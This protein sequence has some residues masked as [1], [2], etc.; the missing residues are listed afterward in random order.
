[1]STNC[2][3]CCCGQ[4]GSVGARDVLPTPLGFWGHQL[5]PP[6]VSFGD[7][8][9][10]MIAL[11]SPQALN[12]T[13]GTK[14]GNFRV[15]PVPGGP[16]QAGALLRGA[17][18][19][20]A[21]WEASELILLRSREGHQELSGHKIGC[22]QGEMT[23]SSLVR[24]LRGEQRGCAAAARSARGHPTPQPLHGPGDLAAP[25]DI[26]NPILSSSLGL[27]TGFFFFFF[28]LL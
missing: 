17:G 25:P 6:S 2:S 21:G 10:K 20:S 15:L 16:G 7:K 12:Q 1:M 18:L 8:T 4:Q 27:T 22:K 19:G 13:R 24:W 3:W 5:C 26:I 11:G 9:G 28:N 23:A 14:R